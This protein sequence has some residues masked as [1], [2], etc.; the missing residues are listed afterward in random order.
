MSLNC[1]VKYDSDIT[2]FVKFRRSHQKNQKCDKKDF[3]FQRTIQP[4][5]MNESENWLLIKVFLLNPKAIQ[6][7]VYGAI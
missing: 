7:P 3:Q 5:S 2:A 6:L 4:Y 1:G